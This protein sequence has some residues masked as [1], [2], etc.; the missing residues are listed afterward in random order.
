[1]LNPRL[2]NPT[3][4]KNPRNL[5]NLTMANLR[6]LMVQLL[7]WYDAISLEFIKSS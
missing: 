2:P 1:M 3:Q 7:T 6:A 5:E 4:P